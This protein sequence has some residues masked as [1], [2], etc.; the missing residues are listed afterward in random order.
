[1]FKIMQ[2]TV[3][4]SEKSFSSSSAGLS[5]LVESLGRLKIIQYTVQMGVKSSC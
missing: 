2:Y 1:M 5:H 4:L 3:Q